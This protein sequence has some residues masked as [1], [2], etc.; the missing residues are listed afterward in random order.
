MNS[1]LILLAVGFV[2]GILSG[3]VGIGGGIIVIPALIILLGFSQ[4][5]AQGTSLAFLLLPIG[6]FAVINYYKAG[7][8]DVK[9]AGIMCIT[10]IIGSWL[11]SSFAVHMPQDI[12]KKVFGV[13]L[14][15]VA[16]KFI[17]GK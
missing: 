2:A 9:A 13:F 1:T 4:Q 5:Q 10:F 3:L 17:F 14:I 8:V 6:I 11:S 12:L 7:F 15:L 16:V